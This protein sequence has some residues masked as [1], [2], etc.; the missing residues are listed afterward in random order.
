[1][2]CLLR[3]QDL[4]YKIL[5]KGQKDQSAERCSDCSSSDEEAGC[6]EGKLSIKKQDRKVTSLQF[7][8]A[9]GQL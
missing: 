5:V 3:L 8:D 2:T 1:M 4:K 6:S 9:R 7:Q